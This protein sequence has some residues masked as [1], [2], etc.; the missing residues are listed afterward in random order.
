MGLTID[1]R[2]TRELIAKENW[3]EYAKICANY[4]PDVYSLG[5]SSMEIFTG[6][7]YQNFQ[8]SSEKIP[9]VKK[10]I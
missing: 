2:A 3:D 6:G 9:W 1:E 5:K 8:N 4:N 10:I 7:Y